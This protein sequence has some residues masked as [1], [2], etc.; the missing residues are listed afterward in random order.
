MSNKIIVR[1]P[2]GKILKGT[3][4]DFSPN[5]SKFHLIELDSSKSLEIELADIKAVYFVKSYEGKK[6][7]PKKIDG[8]RIGMGK[9][10]RVHFKDKETLIGYTQAYSP[11]KD[12][13]IVFPADAESNNEKV[14][15]ITTATESVE[16]I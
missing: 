16:F 6:G 4:A 11:K 14:V 9:K 15:V 3:T 12:I 5:K 7:Y 13:F 2:D 1:Y 8:V 10:I